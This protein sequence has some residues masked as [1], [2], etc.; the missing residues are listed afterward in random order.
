MHREHFINNLKGRMY[1]KETPIFDFEIKNRELVS[2]TDLS[3]QR[4]WP[5]EP[6]MNG[7]SYA[8]LNNFF[9][10]RVVQDYAM[11][12]D[13]YVHAMGLSEYNFEELVKR[14]NGNNMIDFFWIKFEGIGAKCWADVWKQEYPI[15]TEGTI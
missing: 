3:N 13:E 10:R 6:K 8:A 15:Y 9:R 12:V 2:Y 7:M 11:W 4:F 5:C 1:Y 14:N